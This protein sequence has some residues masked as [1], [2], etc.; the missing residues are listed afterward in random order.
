MLKTAEDM[1]GKKLN[2]GVYIKIDDKL[3]KDELQD[4]EEKIAFIKETLKVDQEILENLNVSLEKKEVNY[5]KISALKIK[6]KIEK[7]NEF[8]NL[9]TSRNSALSTKK[10]IYNLKMQLADLQ[11]RQK[12]LQKII[13]DKNLQDKDFVLYSIDVKVGQV[14]SPGVTLAK[15]ADVSKALLSIYVTADELDQLENKVIYIDEKK[16]SYKPARV[17]KIADEKNISK[18]LVQIVIKAPEVFS[19]LVKIELKEK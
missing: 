18:Y 16:T 14:V 6:S 15:I 3:D 8:S 2:T 9:I 12:Q 10:E 4:V 1:L 5:E 7:D 17:L 19:K 11:L 13:K